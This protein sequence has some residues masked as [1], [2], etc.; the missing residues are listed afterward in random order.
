MQVISF[1][2]QKGGVGKTTCAVTLADGLARR[3]FR[4][5]LIDLDPQGQAALSLGFP[6][7]S[8]LYHFLSLEEPLENWIVHARPNLD[9]L[10]GDKLT[11][12]VKREIALMDSCQTLLREHL[13]GLDYDVV[14]LDLAPSLDV[15]HINGLM[16]SDWVIIPTRLDML[17]IDG[18]KEILLTMAEL[19]QNGKC[20]RGYTILPT[21]FERSTR[22]TLAQF[23][24]LVSA[25]GSH[26]WPP[27][28]Q[29][30]SV[31][32]VSAR[33]KTLWEAGRATPA[34]LGYKTG[35]QYQGGFNQVLDRLLEIVHD[36][37]D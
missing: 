28:P 4:V 26:V 34:L 11:E 31:R 7:S 6:K 8:G 22:E 35:R 18:V 1:A 5:L 13:T 12:K 15:L 20:Y 36:K 10:P 16:A 32:A 23:R 14:L 3:K 21:F 9:L 30:A 25:F 33:G 27:I 19:S 24:E 29:D 17:S 37:K 2:N